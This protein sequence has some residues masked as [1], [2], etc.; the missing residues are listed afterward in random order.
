MFFAERHTTESNFVAY[1]GIEFT[2]DFTDHCGVCNGDG[3]QCCQCNDNDP[4]TTDSCEPVTGACIHEPINSEECT[5]KHC[6][7]GEFYDE[8]IDS[9]RHCSYLDYCN[10]RG[11]CT[12]EG[13]KC[14]NYYYVGKKCDQCR[15]PP[16]GETRLCIG[17]GNPSNPYN[18]VSVKTELVDQFL[19]DQLEGAF[20]NHIA[21]EYWQA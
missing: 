18:L 12:Q 16:N 8:I 3:Q 14:E 21:S 10:N 19:N 11:P 9:C 1:T 6:Q 15:P 2:C 20:P 17:T 5:G 13:C 7:D 4:C